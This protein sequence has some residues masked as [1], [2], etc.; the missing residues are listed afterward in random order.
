MNKQLLAA[1]CT[2]VL[3]VQMTLPALA[4]EE[5]A[6]E[7]IDRSQLCWED[8]EE[9]IRNGNLTAQALQEQM[10][11]IEAI[12]YDI[13]LEQLRDAL[14]GLADAS[15]YM[16]LLEQTGL[17]QNYQQLYKTQKETFEQ[18][19]DGEMQQDSADALWQLENGLT[20]IVS[21]GQTLYLTLLELEQNV[22]DGQRGLATLDRSLEELRLRQKL[23]QVSQQT[24][25]ELEQT[26]AD[27]VSQLTTLDTAIT[28]LKRQLQNL[29]GEEA[30]GELTLAPLPEEERDWTQ[31]DYE[32]DLSRAK[33]ESVT[34]F[35]ASKTLED[36]KE[37]WEDALDDAKYAY[38][39]TTANHTYQAAQRTYDAAVLSFESSFDSLYRD[40]AEQE[41]LV[42]HQKTVVAAK[43][44][45]LTQ[46]QLR[47][48]LGLLS[49]NGLLSAQEELQ[50]AQSAL[51]SAQREEFSAWNSYDLAVEHGIV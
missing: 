51:E 14:N 48:D 19:R 17:A 10:G 41:R 22:R 34:L 39:K 33:E 46:A 6:A 42:E 26:R 7:E 8:L 2:G 20:Q 23:G 29:M 40:L 38:E 1:L 49:R 43:E 25:T 27:T 35:T 15:W 4:A 28:N 16:G 37:T 18:V 13:L 3:C 21:G 30:N 47:Y 36:A 31:L 32:V 5:P 45:A 11:S 44:T 12:D 9:R 50:S 24:V